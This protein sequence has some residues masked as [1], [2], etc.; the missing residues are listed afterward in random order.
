MQSPPR[1]RRKDLKMPEREARFDRGG[2]ARKRPADGGGRP[3]GV[4]HSA[5]KGKAS[6][7]KN[8]KRKGR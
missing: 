5:K 2:P 4:P 1:P 6:Y 7:G 3:P 8:K